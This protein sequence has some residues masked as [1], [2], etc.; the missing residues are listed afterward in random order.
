MEETMAFLGQRN[1]N[2]ELDSLTV[3]PMG[4]SIFFPKLELVDGGSS[5]FGALKIEPTVLRVDSYCFAPDCSVFSTHLTTIE[6]F[7][8][9][10]I[11]DG[12]PVFDYWRSILCSTPN[13]ISL[14]LWH[15]AHLGTYLDTIPEE[16][17]PP[18]SLPSLKQLKL[19]SGYLEIM[20]I[21]SHSPLPKLESLRIDSSSSRNIPLY[22]GRLATVAPCL[23]SLALSCPKRPSYRST[24]WDKVFQKLQSLQHLTFFEMDRSVARKI[25]ALENLPRS[26]ASVRLQRTYDHDLIIWPPAN[27][28]IENPPTLSFVG[29]NSSVRIKSADGTCRV[30]CLDDYDKELVDHDPTESFYYS[31][32]SDIYVGED[33]ALVRG[34][35]SEVVDSSD[36]TSDDDDLE[37][38]ISSDGSDRESEDSSADT[39]DDSDSDTSSVH[40]TDS[41]DSLTSG[42]FYVLTQVLQD[43]S[44]DDMEEDESIADSAEGF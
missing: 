7:S 3:G 43:S 15:S 37:G 6:M 42:D 20:L 1:K 11:G 41:E 35:N 21:L 16:T 28:A 36:Y 40:N 18:V 22:I 10:D 5:E 26:L 8:V 12:G 33:L 31:R 24:A 14:T 4:K 38:E 27:A 25:L 13:L 19:T 39:S 17:Q 32:E 29:Y 34:P 30:I 23:S 9:P 2:L 44:T